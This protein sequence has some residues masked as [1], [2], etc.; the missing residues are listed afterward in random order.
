[1]NS[2]RR[3]ITGNSRTIKK[4]LL[5]EITNKL[6]RATRNRRQTRQLEQNFVTVVESLWPRTN[7]ARTILREIKNLHTAPQNKLTHFYTTIIYTPP[8]IVQ[9]QPIEDQRRVRRMMRQLRED[10]LRAVLNFNLGRLLRD[11]N[12]TL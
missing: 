1:M 6:I 5:R 10:G 8:E 12:L 7:K 4:R 3:E 11:H 9:A 2:V